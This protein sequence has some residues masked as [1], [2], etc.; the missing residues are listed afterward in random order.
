[1]ANIFLVYF[2][3]AKSYQIH[4]IVRSAARRGMLPNVFLC[5]GF[6]TH[7]LFISKG[8]LFYFL[9]RAKSTMKLFKTETKFS[10]LVY[11]I[12]IGPNGV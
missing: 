12:V 6:Q 5:V 9:C 10:S 1:M 3:K 8:K 11:V 2:S 4:G 7:L